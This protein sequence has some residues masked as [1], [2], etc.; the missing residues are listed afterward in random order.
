MKILCFPQI[1]ILLTVMMLNWVL[2][3][4]QTIH[5]TYH[6]IKNL[7]WRFFRIKFICTKLSFLSSFPSTELLMALMEVS[8]LSSNTEAVQVDIVVE[9]SL[10]KTVKPSLILSRLPIQPSPSLLDLPASLAWY[11]RGLAHSSSSVLFS[12]DSFSFFL[13]SVLLDTTL[14]PL[15]SKILAS[16]GLIIEWQFSW[17]WWVRNQIWHPWFFYSSR[18]QLILNQPKKVQDAVLDPLTELRRLF[19]LSSFFCLLLFHHLSQCHLLQKKLEGPINWK[20]IWVI[21]I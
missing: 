3:I 13:I 14:S 8:L 18:L 4:L 19:P 16:A 9:F 20:I 15:L 21:F 17:T 2:E 12:A 7:S 6:H 5:K 1:L 11:S 10:E